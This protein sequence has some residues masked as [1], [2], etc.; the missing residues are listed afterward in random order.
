MSSLK[1]SIVRE[2]GGGV[3]KNNIEEGLPKKRG[4]NSLQI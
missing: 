2:G 1:N 4:L 3:T